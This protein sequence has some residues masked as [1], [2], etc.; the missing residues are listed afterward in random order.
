MT[1]RMRNPGKTR[2]KILVRRRK[3]RRSAIV[4]RS[5]PGKQPG[6]SKC[7]SKKSKNDK[8]RRLT[9]SM[10]RYMFSYLNH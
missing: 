4:L 3:R 6:K 10:S 8:M 7:Y 5:G 9:S 2:T 1:T